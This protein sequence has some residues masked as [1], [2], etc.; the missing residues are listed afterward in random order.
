[1]SN[2][3][4]SLAKERSAINNSPSKSMFAF[5]KDDRFKSPKVI[6]TALAYEQ[7]SQFGHKHD[8]AVNRGFGSSVCDRFGYEELRKQKR[9]LGG[10]DG[11][12]TRLLE[13]TKRKTCSFSFGVSRH[14][15]KKLHVDEI[16]KT[17][18]ENL[19]GPS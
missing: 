11:P 1:M 9:G 14:Q 19:P 15:M 12:D 18:T 4:T 3:L 10:L 6:T 2:S 13:N 17:K 7:P 16:L 8:D 5:S